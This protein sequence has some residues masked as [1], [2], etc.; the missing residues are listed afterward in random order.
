[1]KKLIAIVAL[2]AFTFAVQAG[3]SCG[4]CPSGKGDS[5]KSGGSCPAGGGKKADE[6][7]S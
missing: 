5:T 2:V 3:S 1:M 7:K 4:G 6:K